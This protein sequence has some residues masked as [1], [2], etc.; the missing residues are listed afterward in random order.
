M[1]RRLRK[2][3]HLGEFREDCFP[4]EFEIDS[5]TSRD[6]RNELIDLFIEMI[7]IA[8]LQFGGGGDCRWSGIVEF[9]GRGTATPEH[10]DLVLSWLRRQP[11]V[12]H[13]DAGELFD[14]WHGPP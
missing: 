10:R 13:A 2:K 9:S 4:L 14:V 5:T 1:K 7:E 12:L 3:L 11:S 6:E 8:G